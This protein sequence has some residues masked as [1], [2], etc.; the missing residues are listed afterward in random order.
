MDASQDP[1][2][3]ALNGQPGPLRLTIARS[4]LHGLGCFATCDLSAG[5]V[6]ASCRILPFPP[7]ESELLMRTG[8]R[9]YVFHLKDG[10]SEEG[11]HYSAVAMGPISFCNHSSDPNCDFTLSEEAGEIILLARRSIVRDEELTIDYG[12]YAEKIL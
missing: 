10:L 2:P 12:D 11:P 1:S 8:L 5:D 9:N 4:P 7:D 6:I 3:G